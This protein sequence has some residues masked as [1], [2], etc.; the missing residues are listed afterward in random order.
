ML[1]GAIA[2]FNEDMAAALCAAVN[3]WTAKELLDRDP[4]LRGSIL[5]PMQNPDLAVAEIERLAGDR[6]FVQ[7]LMLVMGDCARRQPAL[8]ADLCGGGTARPPG[9]A[10]T[11]AAPSAPRRPIRAGPRIQVEDYVAQQRGVRE[12]S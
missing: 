7:V 3:D 4:R 8:L 9:R 2:L 12:R 1:H 5:L 6:R 10:C 11:P